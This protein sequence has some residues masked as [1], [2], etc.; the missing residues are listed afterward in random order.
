MRKG[1]PPANY[2]SV[3]SGEVIT[4]GGWGYLESG[5]LGSGGNV[6]WKLAAYDSSMSPVDYPS[7][8]PFVTSASW[9]YQI[10]TYTVPSGVAYVMLYC[11]VYLAASAT[12]ARF[13]DGFLSAGT[14]YYHQDQVSNRLITNSSGTNIGEQGHYPFGESWY[15]NNTT[16]KWAFTTYERDAESGN[17]YAMARYN[18]SRL[19]RFNSPDPLDG[20]ITNPGSLNS[21]AYVRNDPIDLIDPLGLCPPCDEGDC[22]GGGIIIPINIGEGGPGN[23]DSTLEPEPNPGE[24]LGDPSGDANPYGTWNESIPGGVQVFPAPFGGINFPSDPTGCTYG[25]GNCGGWAMGW[26]KDAN[27][28]VL[29]DYNGEELCTLGPL[30]SCLYWSLSGKWLPEDNASK[31]AREVNK[32]PVGKFV[33]ATYGGSLAA[34]A[35]AE[36]CMLLGVRG[37][38]AVVLTG[39][40]LLHY[41]VSPFEEDQVVPTQHVPGNEPGPGYEGPETAPISGPRVP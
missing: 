30:G 4:F 7:P 12:V 23:T 34:G 19:G 6:S 13:D 15:A 28:N 18:I 41:L 2:V 40:E 21:Y 36:V 32:R 20:D 9:T 29:G 24:P 26:T 37:C 22:G 27:G 16:T 1:G 17:D 10:G 39:A 11:E 35:G 14:Q 8:S 38:T 5:S 25:G 31:L 33:A 3:T